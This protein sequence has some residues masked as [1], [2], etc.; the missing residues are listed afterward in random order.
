MYRRKGSGGKRPV[1]KLVVNNCFPESPKHPLPRK[2]KN[3]DVR[4]REYLRPDEVERLIDAAKSVG[5]YPARDS[6]LILL[7]WRHGLRVS[8]AIDLRWSAIDWD[9]AHL[10]VK[11]RKHGRDSNQPMDG[12]ELRL[13]RALK[14]DS[15]GQPWIFMSE[16]GTPLNDDTVRK[17]VKRAGEVAEFD[18]PI[19][20]H[21]LRHACGYALAAK[22]TDTRTIQDYLGHQ[23]IQHTVR[24]TE[25]A[26]G[27]F[28]GLW[29]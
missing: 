16:R 14:R 18:F 6:L 15:S 21:M 3:A 10:Y 26:P 11:R 23:N 4:P 8:E 28:D 19:H 9:T 12:R 27:R 17:I 13:L 7:L 22:G 25:L 20:P 24:Y 29:D 5:R 1:L 2:P